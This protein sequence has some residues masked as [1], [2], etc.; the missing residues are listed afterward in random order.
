M[1]FFMTKKEK[2]I[3]TQVDHSIEKLLEDFKNYPNKYFTEDDVRV[4]LCY[5]LL[6]EGFGEVKQT[7]D[8]DFS[9]SLHT[10]IRWW[11]ENKLRYRSDIVLFDVSDLE[12]GKEKLKELYKNNLTP[13]KGFAANKPLAIIELKLRRPLATMSNEKF[14]DHVLKDYKKLEEIKN[15]MKRKC[16]RHSVIYRIV[17]LDK[18][19]ELK[20]GIASC[21]PEIG[22]F[23][24]Y[25]NK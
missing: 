23:Y 4:H 20:E 9:I 19:N 2:I 16:S 1:N 24:Q 6:N 12:V 15:L 17:A 13:N 21:D 7:S 18:K 3:E 25:A 11:A 10:E 14:N 5:F 8:N 22:V